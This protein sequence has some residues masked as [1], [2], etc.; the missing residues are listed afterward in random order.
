MDYLTV[1]LSKVYVQRRVPGAINVFKFTPNMLKIFF[2]LDKKCTLYKLSKELGI[3]IRAF[4]KAITKLVRQGLLVDIDHNEP[5]VGKKDFITTLEV[6]FTKV[7]GPM[8]RIII[9][10]E[11][12]NLAI[13]RDNIP[14]TKVVP[15][16]NS[17]SKFIDD[18]ES[19]EKFKYKIL[20]SG[21]I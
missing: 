10:E 13:D 17:I 18:S 5:T 1:D 4:R 15:L 14:L 8:A 19:K 12:F 7:L 11:L 16:I 20:E 3:E 6:E 2:A 21:Y 9:D